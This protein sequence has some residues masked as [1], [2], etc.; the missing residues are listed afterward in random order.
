MAERFSGGSA[1]FGG[2]FPGLLLSIAAPS[3]CKMQIHTSE[4]PLKIK[5][6]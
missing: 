1:K 3:E 4:F 6:P 5:R 2:K